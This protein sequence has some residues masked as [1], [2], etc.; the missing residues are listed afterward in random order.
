MTTPAELATALLAIG[1]SVHPVPFFSA[2]SSALFS[3]IF[4][5]YTAIKRRNEVEIDVI[6]SPKQAVAFHDRINADGTDAHAIDGALSGIESAGAETSVPPDT[7]SIRSLIQSYAGGFG[8]LN[9]TV[10]QYLR[11]WFVSQGGVKVVA[12]AARPA[13]SN[14]KPS[15][16]VE[17]VRARSQE[18]AESPFAASTVSPAGHLEVEGAQR[19]GGGGPGGGGLGSLRISRREGEPWGMDVKPDPM[20][21]VVV[22][23]IKPGGAAARHN[24]EVGS[25]FTK[26]DG[27]DAPRID[28]AELLHM[29][30]TKT[31]IA[32]E[33]G[34]VIQ[35]IGDHRAAHY[36]PQGMN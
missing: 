9:D 3:A 18:D 27:T 22:T 28:K 33:L 35:N 2:R 16:K 20:W 13:A 29:L 1:G 24:L 32:V 10:K 12:R 14:S 34:P 4:E 19:D 17:R 8:T 21:G 36:Y 23:K 11:R 15:S 7:E 30:K 6:L 5:L 25:T 31:T 26:I